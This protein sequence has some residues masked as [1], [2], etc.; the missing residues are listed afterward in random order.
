MRER[1][2]A[3]MEKRGWDRPR[4]LVSDKQS[5]REEKLQVKDKENKKPRT[6]DRPQKVQ[7][8]CQEGQDKAA[9]AAFIFKQNRYSFFL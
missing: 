4:D 5:G 9:M 1:N 2:W 8:D 7:R 3:R 6:G